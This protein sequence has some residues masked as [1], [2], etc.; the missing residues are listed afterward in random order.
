[1]WRHVSNVPKCPGT[2]ETCR[3]NP[4][5]VSR[6]QASDARGPVHGFGPRTAREPWVARFY[7]ATYEFAPAV[8]KIERYRQN[9]NSADNVRRARLAEVTVAFT[10]LAQQPMS[11]A[12]Q[13]KFE[14]LKQEIDSEQARL[15]VGAPQAQVAAQLPQQSAA[16]PEPLVAAPQQPQGANQVPQQITAQPQPRIPSRR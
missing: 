12:M 2:L 9:S 5:F 11:G 14:V 3:H 1:M 8:H 4:V 6:H 10:A 16:R 15:N 13:R 7:D